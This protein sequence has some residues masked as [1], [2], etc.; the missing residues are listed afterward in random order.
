MWL[1]NKCFN[2]PELQFPGVS[3]ATS[4]VMVRGLEDL[5]VLLSGNANSPKDA[6]CTIHL[7]RID[8]IWQIKSELSS[9]EKNSHHSICQWALEDSQEFCL[10]TWELFLTGGEN[11]VNGASEKCENS[12][13]WSCHN[14]AQCWCWVWAQ[15]PTLEDGRGFFLLLYV[16]WLCTRPW[17]N[18]WKHYENNNRSFMKSFTCCCAHPLCAH[19][20]DN[21]D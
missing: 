15:I 7:T 5:L 16:W 9:G 8:F 17:G 10:V 19:C 13:H 12:E 18:R 2:F 11:T 6:R 14:A 4:N 21:S 3:R 20:D 1:F